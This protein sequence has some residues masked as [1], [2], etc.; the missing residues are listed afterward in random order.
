MDDFQFSAQGNWQ[1]NTQSGHWPTDS[2]GQPHPEYGNATSDRR[3]SGYH[4]IQSNLQQPQHTV[5][6]HTRA[7]STS[8]SHPQQELYHNPHHSHQHSPQTHQHSQ[9]QY[10][11]FEHPRAPHPSVK[12]ASINSDFAPQTFANTNTHSRHK[13]LA[14]SANRFAPYD[15]T[16]QPRRPDKVADPA[17]M[18]AYPQQPKPELNPGNPDWGNNG[19]RELPFAPT[20]DYDGDNYG[21][22][23]LPVASQLAHLAIVPH[24]EPG[25]AAP[26]VR[27]VNIQPMQPREAATVDMDSDTDPAL[28]NAVDLMR[29]AAKRPPPA[30]EKKKPAAKSSATPSAQAPKEKA[31]TKRSEKNLVHKD[32]NRAATPPTTSGKEPWTV[33]QIDRLIRHICES[34]ENFKRAQRK[35]TDM[36]FWR[37][38]EVTIF[39]GERKASAIKARWIEVKKTYREVRAIKEVTGGGGDGDEDFEL[40]DDDTEDSA[41]DKLRRHLD[42]VHENKPNVDPQGKVKT[43][44]LYYNWVRNQ[45]ESWYSL[46]HQRFKG[47]T[48]IR[49]KRIRRSG[50]LSSANSESSSD[51]DTSN[52]TSS[53]RSTKPKGGKASSSAKDGFGLAASAAKDFFANQVTIAE[54]KNAITDKRLEIE[55]DRT[56]AADKANADTLKMRCEITKR[57]WEVEDRA[58]AVAAEETKRRRVVEDQNAGQNKILAQVQALNTLVTETTDEGLKSLYR[59]CIAAALD[60]LANV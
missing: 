34:N 2:T 7:Y 24:N 4:S 40:D 57:K 12:P 14:P 37:T 3:S 46:M 13:S 45:D 42:F 25:A 38:V 36:S 54:G 8:Y 50:S 55:K 23:A 43:P 6:S 39:E 47:S 32:G 56:H 15:K 60:S 49:R 53:G 33:D 10:P 21:A 1:S 27:G 30:S 31:K 22:G 59:A 48:S 28:P 9:A 51:G 26:P 20:N 44:E 17:A 41:K 52:E 16:S 19:M 58:A 18:L 35:G 5:P 11:P 29:N